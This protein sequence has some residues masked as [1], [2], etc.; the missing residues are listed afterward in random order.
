MGT[1]SGKEEVATKGA[2]RR[3]R[4]RI[5]RACCGIERRT[6]QDLGHGSGDWFELAVEVG[7]ESKAGEAVIA[8]DV[9]AV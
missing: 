6:N 7:F 9:K 4:N 2:A 8:E 3:S 1:S 5:E